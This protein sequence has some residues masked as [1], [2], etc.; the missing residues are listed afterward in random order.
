[1]IGPAVSSMHGSGTADV[2]LIPTPRDDEIDHMPM[3]GTRMHPSGL[4][5]I[6]PLKHGVLHS[7]F[8]LSRA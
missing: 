7:Q 1:M 6:L 5:L 2:H 4:A 3:S 8:D